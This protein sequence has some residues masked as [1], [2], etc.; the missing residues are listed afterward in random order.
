MPQRI[1]FPVMLYACCFHFTHMLIADT[2]FLG[3]RYQ[4]GD[5]GCCISRRWESA[6]VV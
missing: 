3:R 5:K 1:M 4:N 6:R 2:E